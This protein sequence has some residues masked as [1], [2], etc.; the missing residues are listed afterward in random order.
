MQHLFMSQTIDIAKRK[1]RKLV[2]RFYDPLIEINIG[3][4]RL[5]LPLSHP[6]KENIACNPDLNCNLPRIINYSLKFCSHVKVI[7]IGA[8][9][10]DTVAF[11]K[12]K[13]AVPVL[14]IDANESYLKIL[15]ENVSKYQ[16]VSVCQ[17]LVGSENKIEHINFKT[18]HGTGTVE[19]GS[20][21]TPVRTLEH[22]LEE[23]PDFK[24]AKF[25][26]I[27]TDG[28]DT[29]II[30]GCSDYLRTSKPIL[31]FEFDPHFI[32][33]NDDSFGFMNFLP[34]LGYEYFIFYMNNGDY[35]LSCTSQ[36]SRIMTELVHYF[37]GRDVTIFADICAFTAQDK[38]IFDYTVENEIAHF[39]KQRNY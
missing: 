15:K 31:F 17:A 37:S 23:F 33:N 19:R 36:D 21:P 28:F 14:C 22:I 3:S 6:L 8:N 7:D 29:L 4:Q 20:N 1:L 27:D 9:I 12:D 10:G 2:T 24:D 13:A 38:N 18:E 16:D 34:S 5:K 35:L 30:R 39:R 26:K 25:L 32:K 11:I